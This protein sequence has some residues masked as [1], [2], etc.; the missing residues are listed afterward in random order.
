MAEKAA[1]DFLKTPEG[2]KLTLVTI[3]PAFIVGPP[4]TNSE[5]GSVQYLT[6]FKTKG[7]ESPQSP[8]GLIDVIDV[9]EAHLRAAKLEKI[10]SQRF[11]MV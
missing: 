10:E 6:M 7:S 2:N 1:W 9:A 3:I 11:I 4:I 5:G 8:L